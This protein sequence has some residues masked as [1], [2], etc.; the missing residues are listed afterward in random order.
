MRIFAKV[1]V[2]LSRHQRVIEID[3]K[4]RYAA[5]GAWLDA[6]LYTRAKELDGWCPLSHLDALPSEHVLDELIR[7]GLASREEKD[8]FHGIRLHRYEEHNDTKAEIT[9]RK[10][11][12][13]KRKGSPESGGT[14]KDSGRNPEGSQRKEYA[15]GTGIPGSDSDSGSVSEDPGSPKPEDPT[16]SSRTTARDGAMID[17]VSVWCEAVRSHTG[18]PLTRLSITETKV[19]LDVFEAHAPKPVEQAVEW[20][21]GKGEA[22]AKS[23]PPAFNAF[24]FKDWVD[25][26]CAWKRAGTPRPLALVQPA[27]A[28][29]IWKQGD[30]T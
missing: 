30:D 8:G 19:L 2:E 3:R 6:L 5:L 11:K 24:K 13:R 28:K 29:R 25:N 23:E 26:G 20:A 22:F 4:V 12:D 14:Q 16:G 21:R 27:A 17:A 7:V 1:D 10:A 15:T 18:R 9:E